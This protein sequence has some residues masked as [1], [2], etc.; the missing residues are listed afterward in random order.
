MQ[1]AV[2][3]SGVNDKKS[4]I[5]E[6]LQQKL[7]GCNFYFHTFSN[8]TNLV[9]GN[10]HDRL[11]TMHYP[12]WHYH[13][14]EASEK[15]TIKHA[16]FKKYLEQKIN[17]DELYF[18]IVPMISHSNL[19]KKIPDRFDL[20]IRVDWNTQ[21]DRQVDL[22]HW[23]RKAYEKGPVGFMIRDNRG[24]QFGS[25]KIEEIGY[26]AVNIEDDWYGFLPS[27]FIIHHRKHF[28][29]ALCRR[30]IKECKLAPAQWGWYQLLSEPFGDIHSSVHGF[31]QE[32][33]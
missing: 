6:Q 19:L 23:I 4:I 12:K 1:I 30:L 13:P 22:N 3:I 28:D 10:L 29:H 17:W 7:P 14:M 18:G 16:K 32:I 20:I 27:T 33:K 26:N 31:A 21:I 11:F 5:V 8:K 25:G 15:T 24:P 2:C 9:P